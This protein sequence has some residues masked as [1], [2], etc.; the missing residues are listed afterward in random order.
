[1]PSS[2]FCIPVGMGGRVLLPLIPEFSIFH[3]PLSISMNKL[4][5]NPSLHHLKYQARNLQHAHTAGDEDALA[6][7][8]RRLPGYAGLLSLA[9]A[10][11]VVAREYGDLFGDC[12]HTKR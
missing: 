9:K 10:Q 5:P 1:M 8:Q 4:P 3:F 11:T 7:V 12:G 2:V 6:R